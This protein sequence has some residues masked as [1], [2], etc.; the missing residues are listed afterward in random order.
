MLST[1][2]PSPLCRS[3]K[4]LKQPY[5]ALAES[6][7]YNRLKYI[8]NVS[9]AFTGKPS[10]L[11]ELSTSI[12]IQIRVAYVLFR[13]SSA[14]AVATSSLPRLTAKFDLFELNK[15]TSVVVLCRAFVI[16]TGWRQ[17]NNSGCFQRRRHWLESENEEEGLEC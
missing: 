17:S 5:S 8:I 13:T 6:T 7:L 10:T 4:A 15:R 2:H 11:K 12:N 14:V 9:L 1:D 16:A 3:K